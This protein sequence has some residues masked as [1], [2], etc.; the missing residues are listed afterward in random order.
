MI[1][2]DHI[3]PMLGLD[4]EALKAWNEGAWKEDVR[5]SCSRENFYEFL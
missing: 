4:L 1:T 3:A 2:E 5:L